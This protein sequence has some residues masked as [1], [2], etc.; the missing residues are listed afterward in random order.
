MRKKLFSI[1]LAIACSQAVC[2]QSFIGF[3]IGFNIPHAGAALPGFEDV[4][5]QSGQ[6]IPDTTSLVA[7]ANLGAS[8]QFRYG[9]Y[10]TENVGLSIEAGYLAGLIE[11]DFE[12]YL[13]PGVTA[14]STVTGKM[15]N[16]A[17]QVILTTD[18]TNSKQFY[19]KFGPVI[20]FGFNTKVETEIAA[21]GF[22]QTQEFIK[23]ASLGFK[24]AAGWITS[25]NDNM[26]FFSEL[27][28]TS[29]MHKPKEL[30]ITDASGETTLNIVKTTGPTSPPTDI[31][32]YAVPYSSIAL[33]IG[34]MFKI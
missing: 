30:K 12:T 25:I 13:G 27:E 23:G 9:K 18:N 3:D 28:L 22:T 15:F 5:L 6:T 26:S 8:I 34:L 16:L 31:R 17:P 2:S 10:I 33:N 32:T 1:L 19:T 24:G 21:N 4:I 14:I 11:G 20:G 29:L 7:S